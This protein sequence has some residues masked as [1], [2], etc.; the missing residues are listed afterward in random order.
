MQNKHYALPCFTRLVHAIK[1]KF[2]IKKE[3]SLT[4]GAFCLPPIDKRVP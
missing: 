3:F 4:D 1:C 2:I